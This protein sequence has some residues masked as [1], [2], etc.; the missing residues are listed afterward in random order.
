M[1]GVVH[2]HLQCSQGV[3]GSHLLPCCA[4][5]P[6]VT[7]GRAVLKRAVLQEFGIESAIGRAA[8]VLEEN[9][10]QFIA[11]GFAAFRGRHGSLCAY[12]ER[13]CQEDST[14]GKPFFHCVCNN[15]NIMVMECSDSL[16]MPHP[17]DEQCVV[18][19]VAAQV[20]DV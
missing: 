16:E 20:V 11:D 15:I 9:A 6:A 8:D 18:D 10:N 19:V 13:G 12:C 4:G 3:T 17:S 1:D 2:A 7:F 14:K 5:S